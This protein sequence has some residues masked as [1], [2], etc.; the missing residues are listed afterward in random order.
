[1]SEQTRES[2]AC[3]DCRGAC[4]RKPGWF[5]P[6]EAEKAATHLGLSMQEFFTTYLAVDWWEASDGLPDTTFVMSP[7]VVGN[8]TG[9]EFPGNPDGQCVF[10]QEGRCRIHEVKPHECA[11]L[12]CGEPGDVVGPRHLATAKAWADHQDQIV[13]LLGREPAET[14]FESF[15]GLV[16]W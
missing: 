11:Q 5:L 9:E 7:A 2:C 1:M 6:G 14:E 10:Y 3:R 8:P 12:W 15:M 4:E 16:Q 13:E